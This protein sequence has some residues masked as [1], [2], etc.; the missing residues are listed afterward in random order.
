MLQSPCLRVLQ[1]V[2]F[3][4]SG[5]LSDGIQPTPDTPPPLVDGAVAPYKESTMY[6]EQLAQLRQALS[7][8]GDSL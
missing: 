3:I 2:H 5:V 6:A 4:L 7:R 1:E 8:I